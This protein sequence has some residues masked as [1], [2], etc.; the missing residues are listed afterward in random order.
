MHA[1]I[2]K[3]KSFI[4]DNRM[5]GPGDKI[6]VGVSG[7][8]DSLALLYALFY[9]KDELNFTLHI[10]HLD[11]KFRGVESAADAKFVE[12][13]ARKLEIPFTIEAIDVP[14]IIRRNRLSSEDGARRIRYQFFDRVAAEVNA[15]K[16]ALGHNADDQAETMLMRLFR[17]AGSHGLSGI[18][19]VRDGRYIRP[20][21]SS[22]RSE[23]ENF[24]SDLGL[25]ARQDSSNQRPIYLRNKIRLELL[26]ILETEYNSNI[27][28]VL[29][30]TAEILQSEAE[31]LDKIA[32]EILPT[33]VITS[34]PSTIEINLDNLQKQHIAIQRRILRLCI[35]DVSSNISDIRFEHIES[36][37]HLISNSKPNCILIL[38]NNVKIIKSYDNLTIC[39]ATPTSD[40]FPKF[41]YGLKVPGI[42]KLQ[43][44]D[45]MMVANL[46]EDVVIDSD[47]RFREVFDWEKIKPPLRVRNRRS[48]DRFQPLGM[49]GEKRLK[50]FFIDE[51]VPRRLRQRVPLLVSD[52]GEILWVVGYRMSD[53][54]KITASTR[55][56]LAVSFIHK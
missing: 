45:S 8:P 33:C 15:D 22:S 34:H 21:L 48:G 42:T 47:N 3:V 56:K 44:L 36:I 6:V 30:R 35:A 39:Q 18:P 23:I 25:S 10:A 2:K 13:H 51:K 55:Q 32:A 41:E 12:E 26:P 27:K 14:S 20:L 16:V 28:N 11:H 7:G 19:K 38:P 1:F 50:D 5:I 31:L 49:R 37:L 52:D 24:L 43:I 9:L 29:C 54:C 46:D 17:G 53:R 4:F 40:E